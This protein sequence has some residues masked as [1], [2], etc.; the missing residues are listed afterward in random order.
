MTDR[1][2]QIEGHRKTGI[3]I[4]QETKKQGQQTDIKTKIDTVKAEGSVQ[5]KVVS[6]CSEKPRIMHS[7]LSLRSFPKVAFETVP[8]FV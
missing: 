3:N 5:F 1:Q 7:I 2:R 4:E 8:M 6:M